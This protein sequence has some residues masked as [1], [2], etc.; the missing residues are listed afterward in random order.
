MYEIVLDNIVR[1]RT[2]VK[3][4][5]NFVL[6]ISIAQ[7]FHGTETFGKNLIPHIQ[8]QLFFLSDHQN[9]E[10]VLVSCGKAQ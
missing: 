7:V 3:G 6:F 1:F 9:K 8:K 2:Y 10:E 5:L 4:N